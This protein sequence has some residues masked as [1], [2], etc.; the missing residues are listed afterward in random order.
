MSSLLGSIAL[1]AMSKFNP[2]GNERPMNVERCFY[3][4]FTVN[5]TGLLGL[6]FERLESGYCSRRIV[7]DRNFGKVTEH[8]G[9]STEVES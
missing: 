6:L 9:D 1:V 8:G 4:E 5:N 2:S 3:E 7:C